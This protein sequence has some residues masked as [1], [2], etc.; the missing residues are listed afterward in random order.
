MTTTMLKQYELSSWDLSDLLPDTSP[1]AIEGRLEALEAHVAAFEAVR[2]RLA[3]EMD[4]EEFLDVIRRYEA[5]TEEIY[6]PYAYASLWFSSDTQSTEALT[7]L[8][9]IQQVATDAQNRTLF[10][11]LWWK[12]LSDE[13]AE[14]LM[15]AGDEYA[16][17]RHFLAD[18]RRTKPFMLDERSEQIINTKDANGISALITV[19]TMLTN[20]LEYTLEVDG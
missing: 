1:E 15:P 5:L 12:G 8:N 3:P 19:Y 7:F 9:R 13:E 10:F 4:A 2:E 17:Y 14:A 20:R 18:L 6:R 11:D 16:D